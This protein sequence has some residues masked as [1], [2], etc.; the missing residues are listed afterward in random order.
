MEPKPIGSMY[1]IFTYIC[2]KNQPNVG[3]YIYTIHGSYG[4]YLSEEAIVHPNHPQLWNSD[5][6]TQT[7]QVCVD[8]FLE[9][10]KMEHSE[11]EESMC[12]LVLEKMGESKQF[13]MVMF[14]V[15]NLARHF[16]LWHVKWQVNSI[17]LM[18]FL[19][20]LLTLG[21]QW[22]CKMTRNYQPKWY[23]NDTCTRLVQKTGY[24]L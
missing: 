7:C 21:F 17:F 9:H 10:N 15:P 11:V 22:T 12:R 20:I 2:H 14:C 5:H 16:F 8:K 23:Q 24:K 18:E 4:K 1:G 13:F 3:I 19:L 6:V